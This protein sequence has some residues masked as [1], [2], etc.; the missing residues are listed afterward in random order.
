MVEA[1]WKER[2]DALG[3]TKDT[4][5]EVEEEWLAVITTKNIRDA[6]L[7]KVAHLMVKP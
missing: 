2:E 1:L 3:A 5:R 4:Q 7:A 6:A